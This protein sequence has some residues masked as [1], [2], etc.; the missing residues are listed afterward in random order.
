MI[1]DGNGTALETVEVF[2]SKEVV[3][4]IVRFPT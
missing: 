4:A 1:N 2:E 3:Y